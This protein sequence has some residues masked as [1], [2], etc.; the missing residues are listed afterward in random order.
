MMQETEASRDVLASRTTAAAPRA[1]AGGRH[2]ATS[3]RARDL[4]SRAL[5]RPAWGSAVA[6]AHRFGGIEAT[7][8]LLLS[9]GLGHTSA[10]LRRYGAHIGEGERILSPLVV[11]N[12]QRGYSNL[13]I[14]AGCHIGRDVLLD[15]SAP[16][17][18]GDDVTVAMRTTILTHADVGSSPLKS[19]YPPTVGQVAIGD[20][21]YVGAGSTILAGVCVGECAVVAAGAVV[22]HDV[23]AWC[24]VAGV[25]ARIVKRLGP[26]ESD[27]PVV[28]GRRC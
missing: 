9:V 12:A 13:T 22:I 17:T 8:R 21:A 23:P 4:L 27:E 16:L 5:L 18:L 15:L 6:V 24:L 11:H 10:I 3:S 26:P 14:G 28:P 2:S 25:P 19:L 7:N 20:G 1:R